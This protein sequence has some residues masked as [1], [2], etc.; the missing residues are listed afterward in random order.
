M[1]KE[2]KIL[3]GILAFVGISVAGIYV[4]LQKSQNQLTVSADN[5]S[6]PTTPT[7]NVDNNTTVNP[8]VVQNTQPTITN[9]AVQK[10]TTTQTQT[11]QTPSVSK[12]ISTSKT[13]STT[14]RFSVPKGYMDSMTVTAT[15]KDGVINS[16][17]YSQNSSNRDSEEFYQSFENSF[18]SAN[19][20]GKKVGS[21]QLSRVGGAS[22]TTEA[23]NQALSNLA[24]QI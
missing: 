10:V 15:V 16:I 7:N 8:P 6:V 24:Q 1:N 3:L 12:P 9:T 4:E 20:V 5:T 23:F 13:V 22:L 2:Q 21:V 14:I 17:N 18:S 11:A 19:V